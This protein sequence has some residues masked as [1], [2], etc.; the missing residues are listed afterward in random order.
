MPVESSPTY[1]DDL[2]ATSPEE[3]D[4]RTEGAQH[5]RN[6][7]TVLQNTLVTL[8]D[9]PMDRPVYDYVVPAS[10]I[11][12]S[13]TNPGLTAIGGTWVLYATFTVTLDAGFGGGSSTMNI[14]QRQ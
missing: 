12:V 1:I 11:F 6:I 14:W 10:G 5:M 2:V 7:K 13:S 9:D 4:S 8:D 3:G